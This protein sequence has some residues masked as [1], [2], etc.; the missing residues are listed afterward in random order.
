[1][2]PTAFAGTP[3]APWTPPAAAVALQAVAAAPE[4]LKNS[5]SW[6]IQQRLRSIRA[7]ISDRL[8]F[9]QTA[10]PEML[11][12]PVTIQSLLAQRSKRLIDPN[13]RADPFKSPFERFCFQSGDSSLTA[14]LCDNNAGVIQNH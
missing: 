8:D 12:F 14:Q 13:L 10:R 2:L 6:R 5:K 11:L 1:M 9:Q 3:A 7:P 4:V